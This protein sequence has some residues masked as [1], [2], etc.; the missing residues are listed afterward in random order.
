MSVDVFG[1]NL[2]HSGG[3]NRGPPGI[4]YKFTV[5]GQYDVDKKRLC[6]V[7]DPKD[8][9][10]AVN[11]N[12]VQLE[13]QTIMN[14]ILKLEKNLNETVEKNKLE[15]Q[16]VSASQKVELGD[17]HARVQTIRR[18]LDEIQISKEKLNSLEKDMKILKKSAVFQINENINSTSVY[19]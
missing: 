7:A 1:R 9:Q 4:G 15:V 3:A 16:M 8:S 6:N 18:D 5:D 19:E 17:L 2:K 10:D 11:L 14:A 13:M 12:A